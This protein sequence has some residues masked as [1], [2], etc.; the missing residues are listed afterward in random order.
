LKES[1]P[2]NGQVQGPACLQHAALGEVL[3]RGGDFHAG[4]Q[5]KAGR[6]LGV[7]RAL[8]ADLLHVLV[9]EILKRGPIRFETRGVAVREVIGDNRHLGV[10]RVE[11]GLC[12]P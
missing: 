3:F 7:L 6:I 4:S 12:G 8:R 2:G 10:L 11:T 1:L 9:H 5:G